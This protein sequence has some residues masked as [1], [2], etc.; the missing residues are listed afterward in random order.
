MS[1]SRFDLYGFKFVEKFP[2]ESEVDTLHDR[3]L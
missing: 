3:F 2:L 1:I